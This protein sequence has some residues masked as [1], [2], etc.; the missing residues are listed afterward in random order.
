MHEYPVSVNLTSCS[1]SPVFSVWFHSSASKQT[2]VPH[3]ELRS[4]GTG[5]LSHTELTPSFMP[6]RFEAGTLNIPGIY[7]LSAALSYLA[8]TGI[9]NILEHELQLTQTFLDGLQTMENIHICGHT[10]IQNR[11]PVVALQVRGRDQ[12]EAAF[13]LDRD[14]HIQSRVGLHCAPSAHQTL[15]TYPEGSIRFSF[16]HWNT[17]EEVYYCLH[18]IEEICNGI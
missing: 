8:E 14:Y 2:Q 13:R 4:R 5:S 12:A 1:S 3:E 17:V 6:D 7:G 11:A 15:N 18:A 9:T 10:D 16:G